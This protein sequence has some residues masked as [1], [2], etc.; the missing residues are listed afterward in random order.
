MKKIHLVNHTH[1]DR[2]WYFTLQDSLVLSDIVFSKVI[3]ELENN[4]NMKFEIDGQA[5]VVE[6]Y[7]RCNPN[8]IGRVK[9][10][11]ENKQLFIGPWYT[12]TDCLLVTDESILKNLLIGIREANKMGGSSMCGYL[13]DTFGFNAQLP[14]LL[15]HAGINNF[16]SWRG[17]DYGVNVDAPYYIWKGLSGK[18]V[19]GASF[20]YGYSIGAIFK[21]DYENPD[22][23]ANTRI[24]N[25][26]DFICQWKN[27]NNILMP[28][29]GDQKNITPN[30]EEYVEKLNELSD[31]EIL[32]SDYQTFADDLI[33]EDSLVEYEGDLR[34]PRFSRIHRTI[35]GIRMPLKLENFDIEQKMIRRIEPL[36]VIAKSLGIHLSTEIIVEIWK[37]VLQ[38][39]AHD[40]I[41]G[42]VSDDVTKDILQRIKEA[43][44]LAD[45]VEN[46][47]KKYISESLKLEYNEILVFNTD[48]YP[49][50]GYKEIEFIS[51]EENIRFLNHGK[52]ILID[53]EY[54]PGRNNIKLWNSDGDTYIN[55]D[56]YY[57]IK[58]KIY[59]KLP[60]MGYEVISFE[61][62]DTG[63]DN[64][65][66]MTG[67]NYIENSKYRFE[68]N[69]GSIDMICESNVYKDFIRLKDMGNGG[70]TYDFSPIS[71]DKE[72]ILSWENFEVYE[73]DDYKIMVVRGSEKLPKNLE[74]RL[75]N[76]E[77]EE[78]SYELKITLIEGENA[79]FN[80]VFDNIIYSHRLRLSVN[81]NS[82]AG[83]SYS[84][85]QNGFYEYDNKIIDE[86]WKNV[87]E[88]KPVNIYNMDKSVSCTNEEQ[89]LTIFTNGLKEYEKNENRIDITLL[90]TTNQL[91][92]PNLLWRPGRASGDTTN[93]G[94]IMMPTPLAEE[95]GLIEYKFGILVNDGP[96]DE[97][98]ISKESAL[99]LS[100]DISYQKQEL[101]KFINRLDNKIWYDFEYLEL[102]REYSLFENK[103]NVL[104]TSIYPAF[105]N[106]G[107][108]VIRYSNPT[109]KD[110]N[111]RFEG[112]GDWEIKYL[113]AAENEIETD[114]I[115]RAY[116]YKT[117]SI[118]KR[119]W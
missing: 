78:V 31:Y 15:N 104:V 54:V 11:I 23:F 12:Q 24:K 103:D 61:E 14:T 10:L 56:G 18:K 39:H 96:I 108:F 3:N 101:N 91:G 95:I 73:Y 58:A 38:N 37:K 94:H 67:K 59:C 114:S 113:D 68:F 111:L 35:G 74:N 22:Y 41:G 112:L 33:E 76:N 65:R 79:E 19:V 30:F 4:P 29:G 51:K 62:S 107:G 26:V 71:E 84:Q 43:N 118:S 102:P 97:E 9:K 85:I 40:S 69:D 81:T 36:A 64:L 63:L 46:Y 93:A 27:F 53:K 20:P 70:D 92:K 80:L 89:T 1:W 47:I 105:T 109:N 2:E 49:F 87:Y 52:S 32:I 106:D 72:I 21:K 16:F 60:A 5:S 25:H 77:M 115:I 28:V 117:I 13:P 98:L 110:K 42:C 34:A 99:R 45:G 55:E 44:E 88:E 50:E 90:S 7:L 83:N 57:K 48:P 116:D 100:Q 8:D 86:D 6:E 17:I 66:K 75:S 82:D 119:V